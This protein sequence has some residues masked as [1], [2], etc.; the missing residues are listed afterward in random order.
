MGTRKVLSQAILPVFVMASQL[1]ATTPVIAGDEEQTG[2]A[3]AAEQE[4]IEPTEPRERKWRMRLIGAIGGDKDGV[5]VT[6]NRSNHTG[7]SVNGGGGV[8]INF[9]YRYSRRMGFEIGA[10]AVGGAVSV[11]VGK[12]YRHHGAGVEV[13]GYLPITFAFNYHPIKNPGTVDFF[14]GPLAAFTFLSAVGVGPG[15]YVESY[16]DVGLGANLGVDINFRKNSRWSCNTG[17]KY[18]SNVTSREDRD[19]RL[20]FDPLLFTFGFGFKF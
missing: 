17:F 18:I 5:L 15:V 11:G 3:P 19:S 6:S 8:G 7:V 13:N 14:V 9:E 2:S 1:S 20:E 4:Q 16:A 12:D 10:M